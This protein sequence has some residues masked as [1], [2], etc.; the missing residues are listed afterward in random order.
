MITG[1]D[2]IVLLG[3]SIDEAEATYTA[4]LGREPDWRSKDAV[5]SASVFYQMET[6]AL[7][8][9]APSGS[10]PMSRRLHTILD[11]DGP[12]LQSIVF[13]SNTIADT[14]R[15]MARRGM[16]PDEIQPSESIDQSRGE[17]RSWSRFRLADEVT[18]GV[19]LFVL[20]RQKQDPLTYKPAGSDSVITLDH[21]V[22]NS[23]D[24]DRSLALYGAKLGL[25]LALD[26]SNAEWDARLMFFRVGGLTVEIAHRLSKGESNAPDKL[27]GMSWRVPDIEAA[28]ARLTAAGRQVS[29]TRQGRRPGSR[30][31][32]VKD[33]TLGVPTLILAS[34][35]ANRTK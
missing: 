28:H 11:Q 33:G 5:G 35:P 3:S 27:W 4:L 30:V 12:G 14:H 31:F 10:G 25:N 26:R 19:K 15:L 9:I 2:H 6:M 20:Q 17:A 23:F 32:T 34:E 1:L 22:I 21:V 13:S 18:N 29:E 16:K 7:E 24:P 8:L